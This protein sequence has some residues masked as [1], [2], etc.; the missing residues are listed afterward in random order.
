M[1]SESNSSRRL[2]QRD[3]DEE[4]KMTREK[5]RKIK[6][7]ARKFKETHDETLDWHDRMEIH[8]LGRKANRRS[9]KQRD[10]IEKW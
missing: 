6:Q 4:N 7:K 1:L 10:G 5:F 3:P 9:K 2:E 8:H